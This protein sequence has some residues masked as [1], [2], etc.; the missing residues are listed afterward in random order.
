METD[1]ERGL[2][3]KVKQMSEPFTGLK[4]GHMGALDAGRPSPANKVVL[5]KTA[6]QLHSYR[7]QK[8]AKETPPG[9]K[10]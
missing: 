8:S 7:A 1:L 2:T 4:I 9:S 10:K 5:K 3:K 6:S